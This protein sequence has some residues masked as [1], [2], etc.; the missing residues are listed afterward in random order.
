MAVNSAAQEPAG[1]AEQHLALLSSEGL[2]SHPHLAALV[3]GR[4]IDLSR[5]LCDAVH[6]LCSLYGSHPGLVEIAL[7]SCPDGSGY[8]PKPGSASIRLPLS[9]SVC[10][11]PRST[12]SLSTPASDMLLSAS[13][14]GAVSD[15]TKQPMAEATGTRAD[16][17]HCHAVQNPRGE[18]GRTLPSRL[19][20]R[21]GQR[22]RPLSRSERRRWCSGQRT[23]DNGH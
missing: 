2:A 5:D 3:E 11:A 21:Q 12:E 20:R 6:L 22:H 8:M 23:T 16:V 4:S 10:S 19:G 13:E 17:F 9:E 14:P 1:V 7:A 18:R 15:D